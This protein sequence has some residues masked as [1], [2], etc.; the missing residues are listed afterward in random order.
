MLKKIIQ[1]A[2]IGILGFLFLF[3]LATIY[4]QDPEPYP[5]IVNSALDLP[6]FAHNSV[7]SM[8]MLTDGRA[9]YSA[10]SH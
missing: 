9:L 4:A 8:P 2:L 6:D 5:L 7:C 1:L 3:P 10:R